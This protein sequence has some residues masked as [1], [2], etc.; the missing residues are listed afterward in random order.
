[1]PVLEKKPP[2]ADRIEAVV[3]E[4][5]GRVDT[6]ATIEQVDEYR[7]RLDKAVAKFEAK[8]DARYDS[9]ALEALAD[10]ERLRG[11]LAARELI[12]QAA[13]NAT[14]RAIEIEETDMAFVMA[15]LSE[16]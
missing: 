15:I 16:A 13:L 6:I 11:M 2:R 12:L 7:A 5:E 1:L 9:G 4:I 14:L 8:P 10:A 3:A